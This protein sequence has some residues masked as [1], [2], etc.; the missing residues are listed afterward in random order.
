M[1]KEKFEVWLDAKNTASKEVLRLERELERLGGQAAVAAAKQINKFNREINLVNKAAGRGPKIWTRFTNG[2]ALGNLAAIGAAK[3]MSLLQNSISKAFDQLLDATKVAARIEVLNGVMQ[4]TGKRADYATT[5][6]ERNKQALINLGI[7]QREALGIQQRFIQGNLDIALSTDIARVAQDAAVIAGVNSSE[8]AMGLTDAILKQRPILLKQYGIITNLD[9]I[10]NRMADSLGK[11]RSELNETEKRQAFFNEIMRQSTTIAG[12]YDT[13][14]GFAGKRLT[15][16]P[17][18]FEDA[19]QAVGRHFLPAFNDAISVAESFLKMIT[20]IFGESEEEKTSLEKLGTAF[21]NAAAKVERLNKAFGAGTIGL[22]QYRQ[23]INQAMEEATTTVKKSQAEVVAEILE[24]STTWAESVRQVEYAIE[25]GLIPAD[26]M[27][28]TLLLMQREIEKA[29]KV[30]ERKKIEIHYEVDWEQWRRDHLVMYDT[31]RD[32]VEGVREVIMGLARQGII[33]EGPEYAKADLLNV[34]G[35]ST[36][37]IDAA[38][39]D[40]LQDGLTSAMENLKA[41]PV[42]IPVF[43]PD[44]DIDIAEQVELETSMASDALD[45]MVKDQYRRNEEWQAEYE[46]FEERLNAIDRMRF[47]N[48]LFY[49]TDYDAAVARLQEE[50]AARAQVFRKN[51]LLSDQQQFEAK[52]LLD[53]EYYQRLQLLN[54]EYTADLQATYLGR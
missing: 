33:Y 6:L 44:L 45:N 16:L 47:E 53:E 29:R 12:A 11:A 5:E 52:R 50:R 20:K 37:T 27:I 1:A 26:K 13:A 48:S 17:R 25:D 15:S 9:T 22:Q 40:A 24:T 32:T 14:M 8:A 35:F 39:S 3:A 42:P 7:A 43:L 38:F 23:E 10:Y 30:A 46:E 34:F 2:I 31:A 41:Q 49:M 4:F 19:Q 51:D 36:E 21:S 28:G 54:E 18:L